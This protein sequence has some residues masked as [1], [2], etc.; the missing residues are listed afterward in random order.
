MYFLFGIT[1]PVI[2]EIVMGNRW[3]EKRR[4]L[5]L[6]ILCFVLSGIATLTH[7]EDTFLA[8]AQMFMSAVLIDTLYWKDSL[9][10]NRFFHTP[11]KSVI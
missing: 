8:T 2:V 6:C 10:R 4:L 11:R 3:G 5:L 1:I 9:Y 7:I